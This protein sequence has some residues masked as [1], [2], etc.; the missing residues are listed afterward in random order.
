MAKSVEMGV[1]GWGQVWSVERVYGEEGS[2]SGTKSVVRIR[3]GQRVGS[4]V[5]LH[6]HASKGGE[7]RHINGN[8]FVVLLLIHF[9]S[10]ADVILA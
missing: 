10:F 7:E 3:R 9:I 2:R 5:I 6:V 4:R 1:N 8:T